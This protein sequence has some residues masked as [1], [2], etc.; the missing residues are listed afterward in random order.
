MHVRVFGGEGVCGCSSL[1]L[2]LF[3]S[4]HGVSLSFSSSIPCWP[5]AG[6]SDAFSEKAGLCFSKLDPWFLHHTS[7]QSRY[8]ADA[9][10]GDALG[11]NY[12]EEY[13]VSCDN[14]NKDALHA[15]IIRH[16]RL[17]S[18]LD[19]RSLQVITTRRLN[20][21]RRGRNHLSHRIRATVSQ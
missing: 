14:A 12:G 3:R 5:R 19:D 21:S 15:R 6:R 9:L 13:N 18:V 10:L 7:V 1:F 20:L 2:D 8:N 17:L 16:D 11:S 4:R